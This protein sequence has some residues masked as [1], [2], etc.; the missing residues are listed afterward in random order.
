M[1]GLVWCGDGGDG[2][3]DSVFRN[4]SSIWEITKFAPIDKYDRN[5]EHNCQNLD[6]QNWL[7]PFSHSVLHF[8]IPYFYLSLTISFIYKNTHTYIFDV[9]WKCCDAELMRA[10]VSPPLPS[11]HSFP[12]TFHLYFSLIYTEIFFFASLFPFYRAVVFGLVKGRQQMRMALFRKH[13]G[14]LV[15]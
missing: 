7:L 6:S 15:V 13:F 1:C 14:L 11:S 8:L 3:S 10:R 2:D 12:H 9:C 5:D 4:S